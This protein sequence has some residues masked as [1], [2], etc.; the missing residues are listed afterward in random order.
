MEILRELRKDNERT[1]QNMADY[2]GISQTMYARYE[3]LD[4]ELP[5]RHFIKLCEYFKASA[6]YVL[7]LEPQI[8]KTKNN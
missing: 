1:Q 3:R 7:G 8:K 5:M 4:T 6:D 2:L